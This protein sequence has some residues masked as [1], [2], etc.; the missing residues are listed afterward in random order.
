MPSNP[1]M[2]GIGFKWVIRKGHPAM[3]SAIG[4]SSLLKSSRLGD[5]P[6]LRSQTR[7]VKCESHAPRIQRGSGLLQ[8]PQIPD[9]IG[10]RLAADLPMYP[11]C[12]YGLPRLIFLY[13]H[14]HIIGVCWSTSVGGFLLFISTSVP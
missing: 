4:I 2:P 3:I 7:L 12:G 10:Q 14:I 8:R 13:N 5:V 6:L 9:E 11:P 1:N